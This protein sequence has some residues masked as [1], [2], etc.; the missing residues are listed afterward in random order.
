MKKL[1]DFTNAK[2]SILGAARSGT[3]C[4]KLLK[5][6]GADV[7]LSDS[8]KINEEIKKE[9][10]TL[11][12]SFEE[13]THSKNKILNESEFIVTSPGIPLHHDLLVAAKLNKIPIVSDIE[14][15]SW[16]FPRHI[17][18]LGITGTNG[19]STTTNYLEQL[20]HLKKESIA[21]G[22]IGKPV[23]QVLL[24]HS[25]KNFHDGDNLFLCMELS[26]YQLESISSLK[27]YCTCFLNIQNDHLGR[28]ETMEEYFKAKWRLI[29]L[30]QEDGLAILEEKVFLFAI[31]QG[32]SLPKCKIIVYSQSVQ[33][34]DT[35]PTAP[36]SRNSDIQLFIKKKLEHGMHLPKP[37]YRELKNLPMKSILNNSNI[38]FVTL[39]YAKKTNSASIKFLKYQ[40]NIKELC[41]NGAHNL[42]NIFAASMIAEHIGITREI[43]LHQMES[44]TSQ[45][46]QLPHRLEMIGDKNKSFY[47]NN[48]VKKQVTIINDSKATNVESTLVAL[49]A[50]HAP[51]RLLLGGEPKGD[52]YQP[53]VDLCH[54][55][56]I[57]VYPFGKAAPIIEQAFKNNSHFL[58]PSSKKMLEAANLALCDSIEGE[59]ILLSPSCSSFDEFKDYE[60]RGNVFRDWAISCQKTKE[61]E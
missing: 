27:P 2:V 29:L 18:T 43:I 49:S 17:V 20:I 31:K 39:N 23:C 54:T 34:S 4:A 1:P 15:G 19:K 47:D 52:S 55:C 50:F 60:H 41:L 25:E 57:T 37:F 14:V 6:F 38:H 3:S 28:Y 59:I 24:E 13:E 16:F 58:K 11:N 40:W 56:K 33:D 32:L 61:K 8:G 42:E 46:T 36:A 5:K 12:I 21:C 44:Q 45:Y 35:N 51:I 22:N 10:T 26:S 7:F 53:I 30:T 48:K 9:L